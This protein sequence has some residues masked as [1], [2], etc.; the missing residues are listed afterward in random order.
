MIYDVRLTYSQCAAI[1]P[2]DGTDIPLLPNFDNEGS[3]Y[4][5]KTPTSPNAILIG[6][7]GAGNIAGQI[8][9]VVAPIIPVVAGQ[10]VEIRFTRILATGTT[11][12][13]IFGLWL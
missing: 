10:V 2:N 5:G 13:N 9:G 12:T 3:G 6:L 4:E 11:A 8:N 1:T 7:G